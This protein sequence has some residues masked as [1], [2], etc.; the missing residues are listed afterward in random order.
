MRHVVICQCSKKKNA[1]MRTVPLV[2]DFFLNARLKKKNFDWSRMTA[3]FDCLLRHRMTIITDKKEKKKGRSMSKAHDTELSR[4]DDGDRDEDTNDEMERRK[5]GV[6]EITTT[7]AKRRRL[8]GHIH[9]HPRH[10]VRSLSPPFSFVDDLLCLR[11]QISLSLC[12]PLQHGQI[13][14]K[15]FTC[16]I[17]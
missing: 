12:L 9:R 15:Y 8:V 1:E 5:K 6:D 4:R 10:R 3:E 11:L 13:F 2:F 17:E 14:R 16:P 7:T